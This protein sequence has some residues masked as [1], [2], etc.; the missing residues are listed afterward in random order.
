MKKPPAKAPP[1]SAAATG[2]TVWGRPPV[3]SLLL[4]AVTLGVYWPVLHCDFA[5]YDDIVYVTANWHVLEGLNR[6]GVVWAFTDLTA[7]FWHPLTWL[8]LMLDATW[9]GRGPMGFHLTNLLL[10]TGGTVVLFLSLRRLTGALWRSAAVAALFALHPL[11]VE[12]VAFVA[13]RKEVLSACFGLLSLLFYARW[14]QSKIGN[15]QLAIGNY[16]FSLGFFLCGLLSKTMVVTLPLLLLLLDYWPLGRVA[17]ARVPGSGFPAAK[18]GP[19]TRNLW[20]WFREKIPFFALALGAGLLTLHAERSIGAV[21]GSEAYPLTMRLGN[22]VVSVLRYLGQTVWPVDLAVFYPYPGRLDP[23]LVAGAVLLLAVISVSGIAWARR[24]P[25][26]LAGWLWFLV[27]LLPVSGLIQVG[28][29]ARADRYT[30]VPLIGIFIMLVWGV[31]ELVARAAAIRVAALLLAA[32]C[33]LACAVRTRDQLQFWHNGETLFRHTLAV[34]R[35]N[36]LAM[37]NLGAAL[38]TRHQTDE[39]IALYREALRIKPDYLDAMSS[40]GSALALKGDNSGAIALYQQLLRLEPNHPDGH[41]NY[42]CALAALGNYA[43]AM[44]EYQAALKL[45]PD[46]PAAHNNLG[47]ALAASGRPAEAAAE[48]Q[49]AVRLRPEFTEARNNLAN[50]LVNQGRLDEAGAQYAES[51]RLKPAQPLVHFGLGNVCAIQERYAEAAAQFQAAVQLDPGY[52]FAHKNLGMALARLGR[53]AEAVQELDEALRLKP[54]FEAAR[55]Q[56][57]EI[58]PAATP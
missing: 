8:S 42:G 21:S 9:A 25:Y 38:E 41:Y 27:T 4:A 14:A 6:A 56:L 47:I 49:E 11:H 24:R 12:A 50:L 26:W 30:Y 15:R 19:D 18:T 52:A 16:L 32:G 2:I 10:H 53:T 34:T 40:L 1:K 54:D 46:F 51:L 5:G 28:A 13:E 45:R 7:G 29:H 39:A 20:Q 31:G 43:G 57:K 35:D 23:A 55:E 22:A 3:I 17:G 37:N 58:D 48:Y 44:D 36:Y 33:L